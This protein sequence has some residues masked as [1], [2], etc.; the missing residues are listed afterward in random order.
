MPQGARDASC[1]TTE[2]SEGEEQP[3]QPASLQDEDEPAEGSTI[4]GQESPDVTSIRNDP[5][6]DS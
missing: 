6:G 1:E 3:T 2:E 5:P 4:S